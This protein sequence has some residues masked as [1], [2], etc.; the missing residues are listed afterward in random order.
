MDD[1]TVRETVTVDTVCL[2]ED[3]QTARRGGIHFFAGEVYD[4]IED[5]LVCMHCYKTFDDIGEVVEDLRE[6]LRAFVG[7]SDGRK[8]A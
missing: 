1:L 2:H 4:D 7:G 8:N 3:L 5:Y 6:Q